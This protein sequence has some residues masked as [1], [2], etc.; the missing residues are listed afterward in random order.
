MTTEFARQARKLTA[1]L[2]KAKPQEVVDMHDM[3][4]K[5]TLD[6]FG[7]IAFGL[8]FCGQDG[9]PIAFASAFDRAQELSA[10]R[11]ASKPPFL[12]K[13]Q[14]SLSVGEERELRTQLEIIDQFVKD[15]IKERRASAELATGRFV[16]AVD[17]GIR[18]R[19]RN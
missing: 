15:L 14:R 7:K 8:D 17:A 16:V 2:L 10:R 11:I 19:Q 9:K 6:A 13:L 3:F 1:N 18:G 12:W 4:F 5:L